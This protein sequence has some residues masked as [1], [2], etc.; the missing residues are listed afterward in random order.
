VN[1]GTDRAHGQK[2]GC[3]ATIARGQRKKYFGKFDFLR[4][5]VSKPAYNLT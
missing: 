4:A 2:S 5:I 1:A 3:C